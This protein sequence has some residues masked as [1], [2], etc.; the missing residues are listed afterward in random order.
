V[1]KDLS[2]QPVALVNV[3]NSAFSTST[4]EKYGIDKVIE[5][6]AGTEIPHFHS[7]VSDQLRNVMWNFAV[8]S[9]K[10]VLV[11]VCLFLIGV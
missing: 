8:P 6:M 11:V 10:V 3:A 5:G 2:N 9:Q 7:G 1:I 4:F